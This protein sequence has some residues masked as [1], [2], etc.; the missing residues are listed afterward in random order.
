MY[1]SYKSRPESAAMIR[2]MASQARGR[3]AEIL[4][5]VAYGRE[6]IVLRRRGQDLVAVVPVED[7]ELLQALEDRVDL[8]DLRASRD[9]EGS[10][11][12]DQLKQQL[13]L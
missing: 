7:L 9:E 5:R 10:I 6:R 8:A 2:M 11:P 3:F 12:L 4:N 1:V 13:G